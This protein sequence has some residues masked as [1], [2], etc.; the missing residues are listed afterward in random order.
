METLELESSL[1]GI[2]PA[3]VETCSRYEVSDR[4]HMEIQIKTIKKRVLIIIKLLI[5]V[6]FLYPDPPCSFFGAKKRVISLENQHWE[7]E[8]LCSQESQL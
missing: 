8:A 2:V 7:T 3:G 1:G 4:D 5:P 6:V